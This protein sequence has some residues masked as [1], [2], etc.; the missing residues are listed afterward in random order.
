MGGNG[1]SSDG[2]GCGVRLRW[3]SH[4]CLADGANFMEGR[5]I[6]LRVARIL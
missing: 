2:L 5:A 3:F 6:F 1:K 4:D